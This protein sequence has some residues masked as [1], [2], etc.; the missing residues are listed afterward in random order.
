MKI[1]YKLLLLVILMMAS[2]VSNAGFWTGYMMG[3]EK[4]GD[5]SSS[6][7]SATIVSETNDVITCKIEMGV[8][9]PVLCHL[10]SNYVPYEKCYCTTPELYARRAG[11]AKLH[12]VGVQFHDGSRYLLLEV[13]K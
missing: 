5:K 3:S 11:Y 9:N 8:K 7:N 12:K 2:G 4:N 1:N 13:S 10:E 6:L